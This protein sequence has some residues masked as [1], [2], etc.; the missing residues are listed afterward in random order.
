MKFYRSALLLTV[1]AVGAC[2]PEPAPVRVAAPDPSIAALKPVALPTELASTTPQTE[3]LPPI[4]WAQRDDLSIVIR[5]SP[6]RC[7]LGISDHTEGAMSS[8]TVESPVAGAIVEPSSTTGLPA[9]AQE[10]IG[11]ARN[12]SE[13]RSSGEIVLFCGPHGAAVVVPDPAG[14]P[15]GITGAAGQRSIANDPNGGKTLIVAGSATTVARG[16]S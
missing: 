8:L 14:R 12:V 10:A 3:S 16:I 4:A 1:L 2:S 5:V 13:R 9:S 7:G 15:F 6:G 11:P